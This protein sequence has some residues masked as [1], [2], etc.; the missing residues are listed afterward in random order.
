MLPLFG[1]VL[2]S[3]QD[4]LLLRWHARWTGVMLMRRLRAVR[5][6]SRRASR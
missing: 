1:P 6:A 3:L 2:V 4:P 5:M